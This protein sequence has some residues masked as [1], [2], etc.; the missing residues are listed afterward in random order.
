MTTHPK[1]H[2]TLF[3]MAMAGAVCLNP[4][5]AAHATGISVGSSTGANVNTGAANVNVG[6]DADVSTNATSANRINTQQGARVRYDTNAD[7]T[8]NS[9]DEAPTRADRI[10]TGSNA[11]SRVNANGMDRGVVG[12]GSV[13][14]RINSPAASIDST[15]DSVGSVATPTRVRSDRSTGMRSDLRG[16][17]KGSVSGSTRVG[18]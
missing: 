18:Q 14:A 12:T 16:S 3:A 11:D 15:V 10:N 13:G 5:F 4:I 17:T 7:G 8:V 6:T 9:R 2:A 1:T